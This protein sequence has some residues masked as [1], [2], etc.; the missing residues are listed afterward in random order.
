MMHSRKRNGSLS[1]LGM[2]SLTAALLNDRVNSGSAFA[3]LEGGRKEALRGPLPS[4]RS[5]KRPVVSCN[6]WVMDALDRAD[7]KCKLAEMV[8]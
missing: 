2:A 3:P 4:R 5:H 1:I 6:R 7:N 8:K